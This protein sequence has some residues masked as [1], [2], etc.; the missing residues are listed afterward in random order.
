MALMRAAENGRAVV[1]QLLLSAGA[2]VDAADEVIMMI[3]FFKKKVDRIMIFCRIK[4]PK[5]KSE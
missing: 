4:I 2:K 3:H 1:V 5:M